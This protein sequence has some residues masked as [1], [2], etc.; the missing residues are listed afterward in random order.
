MFFDL[1]EIDSFEHRDVVGNIGIDRANPRLQAAADGPGGAQ[2][3]LDA[4]LGQQ[5][6]Q[7]HDQ[8]LF[9]V[10]HR[11]LPKD[12]LVGVDVGIDQPASLLPVF[13]RRRG[14]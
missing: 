13:G 6:G 7:A 14:R 10:D 8:V 5:R 9:P 2:R 3:R 1:S 4:D 12:V 11:S